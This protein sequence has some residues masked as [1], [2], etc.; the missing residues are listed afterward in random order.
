M[1]RTAATKLKMLPV[2]SKYW[3]KIRQGQSPR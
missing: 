2:V 1:R 3:L